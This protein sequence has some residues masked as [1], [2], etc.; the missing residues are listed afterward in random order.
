MQFDVGRMLSWID[1]I[2]SDAS[3]RFHALGRRA[4]INL[5]TH[6]KEHSYLLGR[7]I[8]KCYLAKSEKAL[9]SYFEVVTQ[10]LIEHQDIA[11]AFWKIL[12]ACL[13]TLGNSNSNIRLKSARLLRLIEE[14]QDISSK[15]QDLEIS[16]SD[17]TIAVYKLAQFEMSRRLAS[18][19]SDLAFHVFSEFSRHFKEIN[20]DYQRNMVAAI[21]PWIQAINLQV[22]TVG[23]PTA[24]SYMLLVNL[25][26]ITVLCGTAL[27]NEMQALWQ[28]LTAGLY[29]GNVQVV[30]DFIINLCL[31][32][33]E[34]NFVDYAKQIVV[35]LSST[36]AGLKVVEFLLL[37]ISPKSMVMERRPVPPPPQDGTLPYVADIGH[38]LPAGAN[39]NVSCNS[40]F[41]FW[42][43][44]LTM[45]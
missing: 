32:K 21:L 24:N 42:N 38:I 15:L 4:L 18:T 25:F 29:G 17:K 45:I 37:Q 1:A 13:Y 20:A 16:V 34:Q 26:E 22:D 30:L 23:N 2:F 19:H 35:H 3:D 39:K 33:R 7:S 27:H 31:E 12:S 40:T 14:R 5:I 36:A 28:A 44:L 9:E 8:E 43:C 11:P 10:V 41:A 6:N